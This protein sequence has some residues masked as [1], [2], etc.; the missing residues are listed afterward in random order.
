[1][2]HKFER[3]YDRRATLEDEKNR[4]LDLRDFHQT[5]PDVGIYDEPVRYFKANKQWCAFIFGLLS[6][7]Q[8]E[9]FWTD[10]EDESYHA[11]QQI[12]IFE[13]GIEAGILMD[14]QVFEDRIYNALYRAVNDVS[15]Q[16]VSGGRTGFSVDEDGNVTVGGDEAEQL[17][18]DDPATELNEELAAKAGGMIQARIY[19]NALLK[20]M[21]DWHFATV[22][23]VQAVSRLNL[24]YGM[25]GPNVD[26]FVNYYYTVTPAPDLAIVCSSALDGQFFCKGLSSQTFSNYALK[27]HTPDTERE[28][29]LK[30]SPCLT[31]EILNG[32]FQIG[33][34]V[35]ST[36]YETYSCV[37]IPVEEFDLNMASAAT[38]Q[39][40]TNGV[41][42]AGHRY[43]VEISNTFTDTD[44][45]TYTGDGMYNFNSADGSKTFLPPNFNF[46]GS[47]AAPTQAQVPYESSHIYA[48]TVEKAAGSGN[49]AGIISKSGGVMVIPNRTGTL[50][51][52]ITDLGEFAV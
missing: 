23:E 52:K 39:Y 41:W 33:V 45:P 22:P 27:T 28:T 19:I 47:V 5:P 2:D 4:I 48:F 38:P 32:W 30:L 26:A 12:L 20:D 31:D 9:A 42:K 17:P 3:K 18:E 43:L 50:H 25:T 8:H 6:W 21:A 7:M 46:S 13:E 14:P 10:A 11:I 24:I 49:A 29:L 44:N 15:K 1:M 35:P 34:E 16:I 36:A 51:F 40:T 37:P